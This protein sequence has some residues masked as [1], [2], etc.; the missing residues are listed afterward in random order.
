MAQ[1]FDYSSWSKEEKKDVINDLTFTLTNFNYK[2]KTFTYYRLQKPSLIYIPYAYGR[3]LLVSSMGKED[4]FTYKLNTHKDIKKDFTFNGVISQ[5]TNREQ[6]DVF[7][8]AINFMNNYGT[9]ILNIDPSYGK[10]RIGTAISAYFKVKTLV[11]VPIVTLINNW[12]DSYNS[13]TNAKTVIFTN[14]A[15]KKGSKDS[16]VKTSKNNKFSVITEKD[17]EEADI[18]ICNVQNASKLPEEIKGKIAMLILDEAHM[19]C[20]LTRITT[21]LQF[22]PVYIVS[23]SATLCGYHKFIDHL[24]NND[25]IIKKI[26]VRDYKLYKVNTGITA[27]E[28]YRGYGSIKKLDWSNCLNYIFN[29]SERNNIIYN[30]VS[31]ELANSKTI[32]IL[33]KTKEHVDLMFNE[34]KNKVTDSVEWMY[35]SKNTY[36]VSDVLIGTFS[37]IGTGMDQVNSCIGFTGKR[38]NCIII[39]CTLKEETIF[40]QSFGRGFRDESTI[41]YY[42]VDLNNAFNRHW[43]INLKWLRERK[44]VISELDKNLQEVKNEKIKKNKNDSVDLYYTE[45]NDLDNDYDEFID[46]IHYSDE[47]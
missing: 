36:N 38:F 27:K 16:S 26:I 34:I 10:T 29:V 11:I 25:T 23:L 7:N 46:D 24:C 39:C 12:Y 15:L 3:K 19:F 28:S 6:V 44:F 4:N 42:L 43:K 13:D 40:G 8:K 47:E 35:E 1:C 17:L 2:S 33:T 9:C 22:R 45:D 14:A 21:V 41:F 5:E 18:I 37:K 32:L 31:K 30:I 20:S